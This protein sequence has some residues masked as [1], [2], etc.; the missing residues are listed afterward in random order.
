MSIH[1][2]S[3]ETLIE[4]FCAIGLTLL[5]GSYEEASPLVQYFLRCKVFRQA[6]ATAHSDLPFGMQ[7]A[8]YNASPISPRVQTVLRAEH[9]CFQCNLI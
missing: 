3:K 4:L 2:T 5:S 8:A 7:A 1:G 6:C 9:P